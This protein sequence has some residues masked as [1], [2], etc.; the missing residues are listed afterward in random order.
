[1]DFSQAKI[2]RSSRRVTS[3]TFEESKLSRLDQDEDDIDSTLIFS[4]KES[5][6]RNEINGFRMRAEYKGS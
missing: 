6:I 2:E 1:M 5:I 4:R 3:S